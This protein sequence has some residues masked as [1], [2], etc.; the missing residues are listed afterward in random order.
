MKTKNLF[1]IL[2]VIIALVAGV[3]SCSKNEY[4]PED[5]VT[6]LL[7]GDYQKDGM[8]K[9]HVTLNGDTLENYGYVRFDSKYMDVG[10]FRFVDVIPG[11]S[12][13]EYEKVPLKTTEKGFTFT[14]SDDNNGNDFSIE[15]IVSFGEMTANLK[16]P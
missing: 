11:I 2:A 5:Y 6:S 15:G 16:M 7:S 3:C 13:I 1:C 4:N 8:W 10:T 12:N 14:I 9:L